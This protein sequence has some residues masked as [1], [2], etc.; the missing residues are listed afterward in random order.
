[1]PDT[2]KNAQKILSRYKGLSKH[3]QP[4]ED[5]VLSIPA[6]WDS[7]KRSQS[8]ACEVILTN[9]RLIGFYCKSFPREKHFFDALNLSGITHVTLLQ[10][11]YAPVFREIVVSQGMHKVAIR[12]PRQKSEALYAALRTATAARHEPD[13]QQTALEAPEASA[14]TG[15]PP[16]C[17]REAIRRAFDTS[18]LAIV[19]LFVGG[20]ILEI[21]G[22]ILW[23]LTQSSRVGL[24]LCIAGFIAVGVAILQARQRSK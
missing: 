18:P 9:Q 11:I 22:A 16:V 5:P 3:L 14:T 10:K 6:I 2:S 1:M 20:I 17:S 4:G 19:L 15:T 24:P 7:D 21:V 23:S 12:T 8:E 13:E